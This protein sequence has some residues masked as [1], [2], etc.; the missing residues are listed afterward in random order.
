MLCVWQ[1]IERG[2]GKKKAGMVVGEM[3]REGGNEKEI[4]KEE[5]GKEKGDTTPSIFT[6]DTIN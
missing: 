6:K 4:G 3:R 5:V 1:E 2:G